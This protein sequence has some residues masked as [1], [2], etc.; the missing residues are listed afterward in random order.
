ME[1]VYKYPMGSCCNDLELPVGAKFLHAECQQ[2]RPM[3]WF[4]VKL[5]SEESEIRT[6]WLIGTGESFEAKQ[7]TYLKTFMQGPLVWHLYEKNRETEVCD[8]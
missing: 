8:G 7:A 6:F 3:V 1:V 4:Q 2:G 5:T